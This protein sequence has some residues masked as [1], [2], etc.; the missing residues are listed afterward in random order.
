MKNILIEAISD[1]PLLD[2]HTHL[3]AGQL[4]ARGLHDILLYHMSISDLYAAGCP[5]GQRLTQYPGQPDTREAHDRITRAIPYLDACRNTSIQWLM[6]IILKDLYEWDQ[7]ITSDNWQALDDLIRERANDCSWQREVLSRAN[8]RRAG[9]ELA[10]RKDAADDD[11]LQYALEW[12]FFTRCQ[13]GEYDT[14][15]YELER[16]WG[17]MPDSPMPIQGGS[18]PATQRTIRTLNDV[19][20]ALDWYIDH[21]PADKILATATHISTDIDYRLVSDSEMAQALASRHSAGPVQ[22]DIYASY[23][24]ERFLTLFEERFGR[25]VVFQFSF[26]AEPLPFETASRLSSNTIG[27]LAQIIGRHPRM[28]FQCFLSSAHANQAM[29]TLCRELPNLSLTGYWWHNFFPSII[30][31][32]MAERLD[33]LPLNRQIGFFS[34]AYCVEWSYAKALLVKNILAE[35][36]VE[37]IQAGQYDLDA[38]VSIA[39]AIIFDS[40]Q[41]LLKMQPAV[42]ME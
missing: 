24:N 35:V 19:N 20:E 30:K 38:A 39:R 26:A 29:C 10:R 14:A 4:G 27:Q 34:D 17:L 11:I 6:R 2:V 32:V 40:P 16:C 15:L 23:I 3:V 18:R 8:I 7:P 25:S 9:T 36:L 28:H 13:W 33:M 12:A 1:I 5:D 31:R 22:R 21:I 37:K 41:S 42:I